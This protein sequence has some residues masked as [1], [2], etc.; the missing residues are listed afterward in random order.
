MIVQ[1][2]ASIIKKQVMWIIKSVIVCLLVIDG[3][4]SDPVITD[5]DNTEIQTVAR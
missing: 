5:V 1:I 4:K 2:M 3:S